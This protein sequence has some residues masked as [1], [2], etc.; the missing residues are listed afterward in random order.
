VPGRL[1]AW[2]EYKDG[3][4]ASPVRRDDVPAYAV[5]APRAHARAA[6]R[7]AGSDAQLALPL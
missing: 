3:C 6:R 4:P 2:C 1:C 5:E 7:P